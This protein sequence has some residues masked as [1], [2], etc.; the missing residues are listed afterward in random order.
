MP[1]PFRRQI[2]LGADQPAPARVWE[3]RAQLWVRNPGRYRFEYDGHVFACDRDQWWELRPSKAPATARDHVHARGVLELDR[4]AF[5]VEPGWFARVEG[6]RLG[7]EATVGRRPA[8]RVR[9]P[10]PA[11]P[12]QSFWP[13]IGWGAVG[14]EFELWVDAERVSCC[15]W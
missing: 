5:L 9:A 15:G 7:S 1:P 13:G 10:K 6:L 2:A 12:Q 3:R 14:D 11:H 8:I 4:V